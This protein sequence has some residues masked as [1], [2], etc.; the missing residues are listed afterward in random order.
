MRCEWP[1]MRVP[2]RSNHWQIVARVFTYWVLW[3]KETGT[4]GWFGPL[5]MRTKCL[6]WM[7]LDVFWV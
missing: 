4:S 5:H 6:F 7:N 2:D 3:A 1:R